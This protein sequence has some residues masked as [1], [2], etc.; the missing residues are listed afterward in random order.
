M[1]TASH[2][3]HNVF[4]LAVSVSSNAEFMKE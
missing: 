3:A 4:V 2:V 1:E